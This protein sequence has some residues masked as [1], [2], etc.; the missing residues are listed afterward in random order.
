MMV[1]LLAGDFG[2]TLSVITRGTPADEIN[3]C[4]K[5]SILLLKKVLSDYKYASTTV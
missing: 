1:V 2:L 5:A 4:L 3:V